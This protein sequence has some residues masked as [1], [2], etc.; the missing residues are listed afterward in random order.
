MSN[1]RSI[2]LVAR[3]TAIGLA[4]ALL[5][6]PAVAQTKKLTPVRIA[7]TADAVSIPQWI[8][9]KEKIFEKHG[10]E[11]QE[12]VYNVNFQG[13][14][15]IGGQQNDVSI[16]SD[17][18]TISSLAKGI[19]AVVIAVAARFPSGY[20][21]VASKD[22]KT[23]NDLVGK[24][25]AWPAGTGAEYALRAVAKAK[26]FDVAKFTHVDL[27]PAEAVPLLLKGD[28][29][30]IYYWEPW[31]RV[32]IT[33]GDEKFHVLNTSAGVYESNMYL[34]V[35]KGWAKENP[36]AVKALLRVFA[37]AQDRLKAN[38][39]AGIAVFRERMRVDEATAKASMGDYAFMLT[40][41]RQA[42]TSA[43]DIAE[44]LK[45]LKRIEK[46]PSWEAAFEAEHLKAVNANAVRDFPW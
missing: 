30:A 27:P 3:W 33:K 24:K 35:R 11:P 41:D 26:N 16:Q 20:K 37:E 21:M 13:L 5:A 23:V 40:L 14:L 1:S 8:A 45:G 36:E 28:V 34:T 22:I 38:P 7:A 17:P 25:V 9:M 42:A 31:P 43:A 29:S 44:W 12:T 6:I 32:A 18:P 4:S 39:A 2:A 19:D 10:L 15:A 46:A